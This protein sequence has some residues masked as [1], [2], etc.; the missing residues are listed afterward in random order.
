MRAKTLG[1]Y[2]ATR[3]QESVFPFHVLPDASRQGVE[4]H[5]IE[6]ILG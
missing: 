3:D 1:E 4:D 2:E 5:S 6:E